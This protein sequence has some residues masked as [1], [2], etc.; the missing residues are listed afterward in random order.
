MV[1][2]TWTKD[3]ALFGTLGQAVLP[4]RV[5]FLASYRTI[6]RKQIFAP[7]LERKRSRLDMAAWPW[8]YIF[9]FATSLSSM[10][11]TCIL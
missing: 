4:L 8:R 10:S 9:T 5:H 1:G 11:C 2:W 7:E 3:P 6:K